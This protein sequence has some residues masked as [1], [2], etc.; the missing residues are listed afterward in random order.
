MTK[1]GKFKFTSFLVEDHL[2]FFKSNKNTL[3]AFTVLYSSNHKKILPILI[4][5]LEKRYFEYFSWQIMVDKVKKD[6]FIINFKDVKA[7]IIKAHNLMKQELKDLNFNNY[8]LE[9]DTLKSTFFEILSHEFNSKLSMNKSKSKAIIIQNPD[10]YR[11]LSIYELNL[12]FFAEQENLLE[13]FMIYLRDLGKKFLVYFNFC[14]DRYN[15]IANYGILITILNQKSEKIDLDEQAN[16]FFQHPLL[17]KLNIK[18]KQAMYLLWRTTFPSTKFF[19]RNSKI[20]LDQGINYELNS[21]VND[22]AIKFDENMINYHQIN[23]QIL[24]IENHI[25]FILIGKL[26]LEMLSDLL[27][28]YY[29]KYKLMILF[30]NEDIYDE[31]MKVEKITKLQDLSVLRMSDFIGINY[32]IFKMN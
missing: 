21:I 26:D 32:N 15:L 11:I 23:D 6:L 4:K 18:L 3:V 20:F 14:I 8:F 22:L 28:K 16:K 25:L 29:S 2:I 7:G 24:F 5:M 27:E 19:Y 17:N 9:K 31:I 13:N 30:L 10:Q 12:N 1:K